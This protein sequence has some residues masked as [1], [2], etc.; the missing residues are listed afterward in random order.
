MRLG[1]IGLPQSGKTTI[2]N[3]LTHGDVPTMVSGGRI[4]I[5]TAVVDVPDPRVDRLVEI[6]K[7]KKSTYA[8]V[9]YVDIAGLGDSP[10]KTD[11]SG[12][13]LNELSQMDGFL[14]VVRAFEDHSVPH[15]SESVD[16]RRDIAAMDAELLLNDLIS[17]ERKLK[18]L[19]EEWQKGG[20]DKGTVEREQDL[21]L[22][23]ESILSD[24]QPLR[25]ME[26][27]LEEQRV[28]SSFSFLTIKPVLVIVN[29]GEGQQP[30]DLAG[31]I[32]YV[33]LV[34]LQGKL[35][36]EISQLPPDDAQLF[37]E[38]YG[39]QESSLLR[40]MHLSHEL[41][42]LL[43]F[44]TGDEKEVRAWTLRRGS[45]APEAAG[46]VHTDMQR[47]F[48][49]AE[50]INFEQLD[51]LGSLALAREQGKL[52]IEGKDYIVHDGDVIRVRF[53]V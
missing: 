40:V 45:S 32:P 7:P 42:G 33:D 28:I 24:E 49:R 29:L 19:E 53:N 18:R 46:T 51:P 22:R 9:T 31:A 52:A 21:F 8:K 23:M 37:L 15:I 38:E 17:V 34:S 39:I 43:T 27:T 48:I 2:F 12:R 5:N 4:E 30:P 25:S 20:R 6:Y 47:G 36:M 26:F 16:P 14:H 1:I 3:A 41:L 11:I 35:E 50:V 13:L 10:G 44:F